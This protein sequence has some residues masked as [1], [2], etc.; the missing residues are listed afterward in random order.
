MR[1]R[2]NKVFKVAGYLMIF[3]ALMDLAIYVLFGY[4]APAWVLSV[5]WLSMAIIFL[6]LARWWKWMTG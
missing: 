5:S 1:E 4:H 6:A 2:L 3:N